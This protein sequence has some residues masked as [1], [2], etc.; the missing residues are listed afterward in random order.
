MIGIP[1]TDVIGAPC[2]RCARVSSADCLVSETGARCQVP[3]ARK[4]GTLAHSRERF[5]LMNN[6][7]GTPILAGVPLIK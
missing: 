5:H 7:K 6:V 4:Q 1:L 3:G 2:K